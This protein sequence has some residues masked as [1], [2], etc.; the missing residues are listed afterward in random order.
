MKQFLLS[1]YIYV[2]GTVFFTVASQLIIKWKMST[3]YANVP[4]LLEG[5]VIFLLKAMVDP[6]IIT[7]I[8]FVLFS[9]LSWM[10]AMT[11]FE[12]S[13]VYPIVVAG[14]MVVT[15]VSSILLFN[16]TINYYKIIGI[17]II[18]VGVYILYKGN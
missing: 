12:L 17:F 14:L 6:Y 2:I 1:N 15:S 13:G 10:M 5:K 18:L 11:K 7:A 16:E 3:T 8:I 4:E 9:G